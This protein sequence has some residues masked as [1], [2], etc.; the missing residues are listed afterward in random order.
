MIYWASTR[1]FFSER[2]ARRLHR[3][4]EC[5]GF[6]SVWPSGVSEQLTQCFQRLTILFLIV[7]R[8]GFLSGQS[9]TF[10]GKI[11]PWIFKKQ[12]AHEGLPTTTPSSLLMPISSTLGYFE[13]GN[14]FLDPPLKQEMELHSVAPFRLKINNFIIFGNYSAEGSLFL[15][16]YTKCSR[17]K[18]PQ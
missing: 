8:M 12:L 14:P 4:M 2:L 10:P 13:Y 9:M 6:R 18:P 3:V 7:S 5:W 1:V 17:Y 11:D 16:C 15:I